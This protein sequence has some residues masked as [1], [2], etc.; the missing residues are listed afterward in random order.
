M[1]HDLV[2]KTSEPV[3]R[4]LSDAGIAASELGQVLL[5]GGSTRIPA[6][7]EE[8]KRLTGKEPSK[9]LNPDECVALGASVQGG[10]LAG[11]AGAGDILLLD[12][13]PLSLSIDREEYDDPDKEEPDL[14]Y[15]RG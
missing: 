3:Q 4:A 6:V 13:T 8:V 12:V 5:V 1:T 15:S 10:K 2:M 14:L 7:Q 9:S 11:D